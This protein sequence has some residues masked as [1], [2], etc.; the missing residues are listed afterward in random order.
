MC[1]RDRTDAAPSYFA[2]GTLGIDR[3]ASLPERGL[4]LSATLPE[5]DMD[6]WEKVSDGFDP[7]PVKGRPAPRPLL[8]APERV[9]LATGLLRTSGYT[10]N[11]LTLYA[12]RPA[13]AQWRVDIQ[14]R[15]AAGS[16]S[17]RCLLYTS[18]CV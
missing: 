11:D 2:R 12:T 10:L 3:P 18:R 13:P 7:P 8:P 16:L 14:S 1:I 15:Q 5:L 9:S 4:S 17:W 6:A